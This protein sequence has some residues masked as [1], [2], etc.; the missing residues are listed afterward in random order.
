[1]IGHLPSSTGAVRTLAEL[2]QTGSALCMSEL[3]SALH[4]TEEDA[5]ENCTA[6]ARGAATVGD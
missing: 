6:H 3:L 1:M 5:W 4:F 2:R